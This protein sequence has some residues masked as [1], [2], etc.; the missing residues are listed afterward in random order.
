MAQLTPNIYGPVYNIRL[1]IYY[2]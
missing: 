1:Y 2:N